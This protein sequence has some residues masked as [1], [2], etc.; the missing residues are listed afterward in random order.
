MVAR[1]RSWDEV[2]NVFISLEKSHE[3][4]ANVGFENIR[5]YALDE[6]NFVEPSHSR[7]T[8]FVFSFWQK[9]PPSDIVMSLKEE[10]VEEIKKQSTKYGFKQTNYNIYAI[11]KKPDR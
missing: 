3:L 5:V 2:C 4:F 10:M 7:G 1:A 6:I 8:G 9:D 11:G